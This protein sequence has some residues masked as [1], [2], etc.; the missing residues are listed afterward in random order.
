MLSFWQYWWNLYWCEKRYSIK[1]II[2]WLSLSLSPI[3]IICLGEL[4]QNLSYCSC[5][6]CICWKLHFCWT[7]PPT[8]HPP[9]TP[10]QQYLSCYLP[11]FYQ[12]WNIG[13]WCGTQLL[14]AA[15]AVAGFI[16][17]ELA[18]TQCRGCSSIAA[19]VPSQTSGNWEQGQLGFVLDMTDYSTDFSGIQKSCHDKPTYELVRRSPSSVMVRQSKCFEDLCRGPSLEEIC[20]SQSFSD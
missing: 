2:I 7:P 12:T 19:A 1:S 16:Q 9:G 4:V 15:L 6:I 8:T 11:N 14:L 20:Q 17:L 18:K 10:R 3:L 5:D 13:S